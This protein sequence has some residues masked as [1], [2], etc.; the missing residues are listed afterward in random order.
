MLIVGRELADLWIKA[1]GNLKKEDQQ[2]FGFSQDDKRVALEL[3]IQTIE[4]QKNDTVKAQLKIQRKQGKPI[5]LRDVLAKIV[6][7]VSKFKEVGDVITQYDPGHAALPWAAVRLVL[8]AAVG[9]QQIYDSMLEGLEH[10]ADVTARYAWVETLYLHA[11]SKMRLQLQDSIVKLYAAVLDFLAKARRHYSRHTYQRVLKSLVQ[12]DEQAVQKYLRTIAE[13]EEKVN[14]IARLV[15][16]QYLREISKTMDGGFSSLLNRVDGISQQITALQV[17]STKQKPASDVE[18][19]DMLKWLDPVSTYEDYHTAKVAR[20]TGTCDWILQREEFQGWLNS[21]DSSDVTRILWFHGKPGTGKTILSARMTEHLLEDRS[22]LFA[23]FFC[24]YGNDLKRDCNSIIK[25]WIAQIVKKDSDA[26]SIAIA[27]HREKESGF[28]NRFEIWQ[29]FR[30]INALARTQYYLV[31]GFDECDRNDNGLPNHD[32]LDAKTRF[33]TQLIEATNGNGN[34]LL[35][36]SR[37]DAEIRDQMHAQIQ[38]ARTTKFEWVDSR[39]TLEDTS[40]DLICF[41]QSVI[42][43]KLPNRYVSQI[44]LTL[45]WWMQ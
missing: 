36:M 26:C 44:F 6:T 32:L 4:K 33:L 40:D 19:E 42:T 13:R 17:N 1:V 18:I 45:I 30:R 27:V 20:Q 22:R 11:S 31:D 37:P 15:D 8:Q 24:Y 21:E 35:I 23:F 34:R 43:R 3:L 39:I 14:N 12:F 38:D 16:A 7:C 25:A 41:T 28:A 29:I 2:Q 9:E 5:V 10:V